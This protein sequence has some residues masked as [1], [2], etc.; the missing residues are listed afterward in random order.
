M[1]CV[2][3]FRFYYSK[4]R[5]VRKTNRGFYVASGVR[6]GL[7]SASN[8]ALFWTEKLFKIEQIAWQSQ[9]NLLF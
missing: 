2:T 7:V 8:I 3:L 4:P 9:E 5:L 1:R 6:V